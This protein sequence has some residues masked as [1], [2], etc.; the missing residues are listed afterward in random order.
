VAAI[1]RA[2]SGEGA[3]NT[4]TTTASSLRCVLVVVVTVSLH[5][6][7]VVDCFTTSS[8]F[9]L[10][11]FR[12]SKHRV[13]SFLH[14]PYVMQ[15]NPSLLCVWCG[16]TLSLTRWSSILLDLFCSLLF[17]F[18]APDRLLILSCC[19]SVSLSVIF[20][21]SSAAC[22]CWKFWNPRP[23]LL[24]LSVIVIL[25]FSPVLLPSVSRRLM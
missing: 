23:L 10:T 12:T 22:A 19:L 14:V 20:Y 25:S 9:L 16:D 18:L 3:H 6:V 15:T 11:C 2:T 21:C 17:P 8:L 5:L 7:S 13:K 4:I 24:S 1:A